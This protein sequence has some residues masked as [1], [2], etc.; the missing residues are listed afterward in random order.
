MDEKKDEEIPETPESPTDSVEEE[1]NDEIESIA[2]PAS[3]NKIPNGGLV[4]WLQVLGSF[5][6]FM[7]SWYYA[8]HDVPSFIHA[9]HTLTLHP[10]V[11]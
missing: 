4:A 9:P 8:P 6:M 10:G 1:R 7:N 5:F 11:S 2:A 3:N